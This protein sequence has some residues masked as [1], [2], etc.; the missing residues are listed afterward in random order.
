MNVR[1]ELLSLESVD[2]P[3]PFVQGLGTVSSDSVPHEHH[4][5]W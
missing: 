4:I 3:E 2:S 1:K 5:L